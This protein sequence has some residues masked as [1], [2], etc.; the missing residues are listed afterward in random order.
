MYVGI[1]I[2]GNLRE[3][4]IEHTKH[5]EAPNVLLSLS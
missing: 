5:G 3:S 1:F 2:A 4:D